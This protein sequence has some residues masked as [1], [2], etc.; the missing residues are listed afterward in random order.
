MDN[1]WLNWIVNGGPMPEL[2]LPDVPPVENI[3]LNGVG[4]NDNKEHKVSKTS[5]VPTRD[6]KNGLPVVQN[7]GKL[8]EAA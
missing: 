8:R 4:R 2:D 3:K 5:D 7:E 6:K 1:K